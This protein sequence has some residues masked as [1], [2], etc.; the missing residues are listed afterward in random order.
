MASVLAFTKLSAFDLAAFSE[1]SNSSGSLS[2]ISLFKSSRFVST[3][4]CASTKA[5]AADEKTAALS[6]SWALRF[7]VF[8]FSVSSNVF[9][10]VTLFSAVCIFSDAVL[11]YSCFALSAASIC[12]R[13]LSTSF[14]CSLYA[15]S[16]ASESFTFFSISG[17]S[18][19]SR[20]SSSGQMLCA[21]AISFHSSE[22][23]AVS[24]RSVSIVLLIPSKSPLFLLCSLV[25]CCFS[26]CWALI[27]ARLPS[28]RAFISLITGK[29]ASLSL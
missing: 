8:P 22:R 25:S 10:S 11:V 23:L 12:L 13:S 9:A 1:F 14:T 20:S 27:C 15:F 3:I 2:P 6:E 29:M 21:Q 5:S 7:S 17:M 28:I 16:S 24:E 26:V 4:C 18:D 19:L